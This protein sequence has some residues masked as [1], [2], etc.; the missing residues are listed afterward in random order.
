MQRGDERDGGE[1]RGG[2]AVWWRGEVVYGSSRGGGLGEL[3]VVEGGGGGVWRGATVH[4]RRGG[5]GQGHRRV[6]V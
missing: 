4:T 5:N 1:G 3:V 6:G 2:R